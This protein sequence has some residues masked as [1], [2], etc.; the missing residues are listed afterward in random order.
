MGPDWPS[1]GYIAVNTFG[2]ANRQDRPPGHRTRHQGLP[3]TEASS[4]KAL[5]WGMALFLPGVAVA[6]FFYFLGLWSVA[7]LASLVAVAGWLALASGATTLATKID[8]LHRRHTAE[9][10]SAAEG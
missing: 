5:G 4:A 1:D 9:L 6:I 2:E 8:E 7:I 3:V 10:A